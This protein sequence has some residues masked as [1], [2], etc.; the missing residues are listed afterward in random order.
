MV[1]ILATFSYIVILRNCLQALRRILETEE[2][3]RFSQAIAAKLEGG[4]PV[5]A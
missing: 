3:Q 2:L 4:R 5:E 1:Y